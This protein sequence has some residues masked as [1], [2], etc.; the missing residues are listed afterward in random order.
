[1]SV[2]ILQGQILEKKRTRVRKDLYGVVVSGTAVH[3]GREPMHSS[4]GKAHSTVTG[5]QRGKDAYDYHELSS[6]SPFISKWAASLWGS[7][8]HSQGGSYLVG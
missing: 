4:R 6:F 7:A 1:M 3:H 8:T 2:K 5:K